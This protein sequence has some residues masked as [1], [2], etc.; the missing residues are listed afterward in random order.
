[1]DQKRYRALE[2]A[3]RALS[4]C[5]VG[6]EQET[7]RV[8]RKGTL[9]TTKHPS[10][11]GSPYT[12]KT[13][14]LDFGKQQ[15][16]LITSPHTSMKGVFG[17]LLE[18]KQ[19]V[20]QGVQKEALWP[21]SMPPVLGSAIE[22]ADFG[23]TFGG[24][25]KSIYRKGLSKRY[26]AE[27]QLISG[28][29]FN[30]S[31]DET[32]WDIFGENP[33][34]AY[35]HICRNFLRYGWIV[36]YLFGASP[37]CDASYPGDGF[38]KYDASTKFFPFATTLRMSP[39]GYY[40][41]I[42]SQHAVSY[43]S[44]MEYVESLRNALRIHKKQYES[45]SDQLNPNILQ[46]QHEHYAR[47]RP[48]T[49][50]ESIETEGVSYIEVRSI[51]LD[52]FEPLGIEK[53]QYTFIQLFLL[54]CLVMDSP[55][56]SEKEIKILCKNQSD[57]ALKGRDPRLCLV[58]NGKKMPL[59]QWAEE[60]IDDMEGLKHLV[61]SCSFVQYRN[62]INNPELTLSG[63]IL[64]YMN[65]YK[66][67]HSAMG[68][69]LAF[70]HKK[71]LSENVLS[72]SA[73]ERQLSLVTTSKN[74]FELAKK[75]EQVVVPGFEDMELSSQ[76]LLRECLR[77]QIS[78]EVLDRSANILRLTQNGKTEIVRQATKTSLDSYNV[79]ELMGNK[80]VTKK[81][82]KERGFS[83][84]EGGAASTFSMA[85]LLF[86]ELQSDSVVVKP[87]TTNYGHGVHI[88]PKKNEERLLPA[89]K[90]CFALDQTLLV[91]EFLEGTEYR[92]L[93]IDGK[94][95]G[96]IER[97]PA[98]VIGDGRSSISQLVASKNN[99]PQRYRPLTER[100][101]LGSHEIQFLTFQK[102]TP[103][104][105]LKR[106]KK[107]FLRQNTNVSTGGSALD[108]TDEIHSYY[109]KIAVSATQS[110][111][112]HICGIDMIV[113]N[114][115]EKGPYGIIELNYNPTI[116]LHEM[117]H[118]GTPRPIARALLMALGFDVKKPKW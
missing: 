111:G 87:N 32:F 17:E 46:N 65:E 103:Q 2:R 19:F 60:I 7:V 84:A 11:L 47:I 70:E 102:L 96:V 12:H 30:L 36:S 15:L 76:F 58:N 16:E 54:Y 13:I 52:P 104:S 56:L 66:L 72:E 106:G 77:Q 83:V 45:I 14:S 115:S 99:D 63:K 89:C 55:P 5:K 98:H 61:P 71:V 3:K 74:D 69:K 90:E 114:K 26:G 105:V 91:E 18:T 100:L 67:T 110:I 94:C 79:I 97:E 44:P 86:N 25:V 118:K 28:I 24:K 4:K 113:K 92:F 9:A 64:S 1:M 51:D 57:V 20:S 93:V 34:T 43:N 35:M 8:T 116:A 37:V 112:A 31:F 73:R 38:K 107:V 108:R 49:T 6:L 48:K 33:S 41:K 22:V 10:A 53:C 40:S 85:Q 42:Q 95:V 39:Y 21:L 59:K 23:D 117:P 78:V 88:F 101:H 82:L 75:L 27:M 109:K 81:L 50:I 68:T 80:V 62:A 29:H